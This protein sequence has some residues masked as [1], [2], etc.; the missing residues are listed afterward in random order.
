MSWMWCNEGRGR[1]ARLGPGRGT[2][3]M[4]GLS[5]AGLATTA[6]ASGQS[7]SDRP[8]R[9]ASSHY[10]ACNWLRPGVFGGFD[11]APVGTMRAAGQ[12]LPISTNVKLYYLLGDNFGG[13]PDQT[14]GLPDMRGKAPTGLHY[15]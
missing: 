9:L 12:L 10:G 6:V 13:Q 5:A 15:V 7:A 11:F 14:F 3:V 4:S 2:V 8:A 1:P